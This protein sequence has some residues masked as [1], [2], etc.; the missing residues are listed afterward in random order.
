M[1][2]QTSR[3]PDNSMR[4]ARR[5]GASFRGVSLNRWTMTRH[6]ILALVFILVWYAI[7]LRWVWLYRH[8]NLFDVDEAGYLS[9]AAAAARS[10]DLH[11]WFETVFGNIQAPVTTGA[12]AAIFSLFGIHP[13]LGFLVPLTCAALALFLMFSMG[14]RMG[15]AAMAWSGLILVATMPVFVD[16]SRSISFAMASTL[17]TMAT[18]YC[19]LRSDGMASLRWAILFGLCMG[20]MPLSRTL[21]VAYVPGIVL[22][23]LI[24]S[25]GREDSR[26]RLARLV[27]ATVLAAATTA[28]WLV[29]K[30]RAVW[31]Y[32]LDF[33]YGQSTP[34]NAGKTSLL[35]W[36]AWDT[37]LRY[38]LTS[39]ALTFNYD[40]THVIHAA[41]LL[42]GVTLTAIFAVR[43]SRGLA[44][45]QI[46]RKVAHST[47]L[48]PALLFT[49]GTVAL[50]STS[51]HGS[52]FH[53]PLL[54]A[55]TL[56]SAWGLTRTREYVR[57]GFILVVA[58]AALIVY[59]PEV[60]LRSPFAELRGVT[61]PGIGW[62]IVTDGRGTLQQAEAYGI[63]AGGDW[64][65][66]PSP[67]RP[68]PIDA[69]TRR[70]WEN[71]IA[72][73]VEFVRRENQPSTPV[74]FGFN[75]IIYNVNSLEL[76]QLTRYDHEMSK[77]VRS[78]IDRR[79][80]GPD[81]NEIWWPP[82][83]PEDAYFEWLT[84][85]A[86]ASCLLFT[87]AGVVNEYLPVIDSEMLL[88]AARRAHFRSFA[89]WKLPDGR[90]VVAWRRESNLCRKNQ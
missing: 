9:I 8:E 85:S 42:V 29:P 63:W 59:V 51:N 58:A 34:V 84:Q 40:G 87:S 37:T 72:Q 67:L 7:G 78:G 21:L 5:L 3:N 12:I 56:V 14:L 73:A 11:G 90:D 48:G 28:V 1:L 15:G 25:L 83:K 80:G 44:P 52:G 60:D 68:E 66:P 16:Y 6:R 64:S 89:G 86:G 55:L 33:G 22:A 75:H 23:A 69:A 10:G 81:F 70:E 74:A 20:L 19:L 53:P 39:R 50:A 45:L 30:W 17:A 26:R 31:H 62:S 54:S 71:A 2:D 88:S 24:S 27:G 41:I 35:H 46:V 13:I 82:G 61:I 57:R 36:D 47:L 32:L 18:L 79:G 77:P 76:A 49:V 38:Y 43:R 65:W 4:A